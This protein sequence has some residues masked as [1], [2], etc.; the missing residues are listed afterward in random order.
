MRRFKKIMIVFFSTLFIILLLLFIFISVIAKFLIEKYDEKYTG[1][2]I[3]LDWAY[4][5]PLT[6]Y[7]YL[8]NL[9]VY[10][11]NNQLVKQTA[12]S[13]FFMANSVSANFAML[14]GTSI[15]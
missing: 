7:I 10:E 3:T 13:V 1:R 12:D 6:G 14:K 8:K 11:Q 9:K 5:N 4:V 2:Q 15:I